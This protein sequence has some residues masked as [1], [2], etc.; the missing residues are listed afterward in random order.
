LVAIVVTVTGLPAFAGGAYAQIPASTGGNVVD[1]PLPVPGNPAFECRV[2]QPCAAFPQFSPAR[3]DAV[4]QP[5][6][7]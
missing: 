1:H 5:R 6:P 2:L 7:D 3:S 4:V